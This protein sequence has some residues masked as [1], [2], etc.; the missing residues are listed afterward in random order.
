MSVAASRNYAS[1]AE[2][3]GILSRWSQVVG[4]IHD[5]LDDEGRLK[6]VLLRAQY[7]KRDHGKPASQNVEGSKDDTPTPMGNRTDPP[8]RYAVHPTQLLFMLWCVD[9]SNSVSRHGSKKALG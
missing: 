9:F 3:G 7:D 4:R 6:D 8:L 2:A 5:H 1:R